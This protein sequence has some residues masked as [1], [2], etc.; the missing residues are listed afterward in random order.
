MSTD[1]PIQHYSAFGELMD[2]AR[3]N[4]EISPF[5]D[6]GGPRSLPPQYCYREIHNYLTLWDAAS[7]QFLSVVTEVLLISNY[8]VKSV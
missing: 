4:F 2:S 1:C 7:P 8:K 3:K 6:R 5:K